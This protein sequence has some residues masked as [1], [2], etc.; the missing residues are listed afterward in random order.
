[1]SKSNL[2]LNHYNPKQDYQEDEFDELVRIYQF[3]DKFSEGFFSDLF[4]I[5]TSRR[6]KELNR[7]YELPHEDYLLVISAAG[8][9]DKSSGLT[10][11]GKKICDNVYSQLKER[12]GLSK[13]LTS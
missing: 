8:V 7:V 10:P 2:Y 1:M 3:S 9:L 6:M 4:G 5:Q 12:F 13:K 11:F